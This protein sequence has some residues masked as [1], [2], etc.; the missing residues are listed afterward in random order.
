MIGSVAVATLR[1][2]LY[3]GWTV[4]LLPVQILEAAWKV[5]WGDAVA[6]PLWAVHRLAPAT[7][8]V[9]S[10]CLWVVI[11]LIAITW[12]YVVAQYVVKRGERW[13]SP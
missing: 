10:D 9:A 13:R 8:Q 4:L 3:L 5:V 12:R 6:W 1:L 2:A 7:R 11:V